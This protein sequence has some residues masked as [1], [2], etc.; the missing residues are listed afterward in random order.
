M[1]SSFLAKLGEGWTVMYLETEQEFNFIKQALGFLRAHYNMR[2]RIG[3]SSWRNSWLSGEEQPIQ[4]SDY[5]AGIM[6]NVV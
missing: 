5:I 4:Y 6:S 3:G 1:Y 2:F